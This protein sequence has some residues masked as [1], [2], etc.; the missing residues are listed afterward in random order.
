MA[1]I[2]D[3]NYNREI[4]S[5]NDVISK[6]PNNIKHLY[7]AWSKIE[8]SIVESRKDNSLPMYLLNSYWVDS[9]SQKDI[10]GDLKVSEGIVRNMFDKFNIPVRYT[11][12]NDEDHKNLALDYVNTGLVSSELAKKYNISNPRH[13]LALAVARGWITQD[14]RDDASIRK[15][16][17]TRE[18][19]RIS[20]QEL[21]SISKDYINTDISH[22]DLKQRY[23]TNRIDNRLKLAVSRGII[24]QQ[25]KD[26]ALNRRTKERAIKSFEKIKPYLQSPEAIKR[27]ANSIVGRVASEETKEKQRLAH[28]TPEAIERDT[29]KGL[30]LAKES[31]KNKY[32]VDERF[33]ADSLQEGATA[34]MLEKYL[35][36]Y[37]IIE[38]KNFQVSGDT[39]CFFDFLIGDK[40]LEWHPTIRKHD[41]RYL[42]E[43]NLALEEILRE[44]KT[45]EDKRIVKEM[46][47]EF[48]GELGVQY[49]ISRQDAS[50]N[51]QIYNGGEVI[52]VKTPKELY[53]FLETQTKNLPSRRDF[54]REF[55][56]KQ[57]SIKKSN[58]YKINEKAA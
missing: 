52:V 40:I 3:K 18:R 36:N 14:Q 10:A 9:K 2:W 57:R 6:A 27:R 44:A 45:P 1:R 48:I 30:R 20:N 50:D 23:S 28:Q 56:T 7:G 39:P 53:E 42:P 38:G 19:V 12:S 33:Y 43:D 47:R 17:K 32:P 11:S 22:E 29:Q 41:K 5:L 21:E 55:N 58:L 35:S 16:N 8:H 37:K 51:S 26:L 34:L 31:R 46:T 54:V 13:S 24:T 25:E 15:Q 4:K 49:W